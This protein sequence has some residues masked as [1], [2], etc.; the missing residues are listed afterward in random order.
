MAVPSLFVTAAVLAATPS[1]HA[2]TAN[3][4]A[5]NAYHRADQAVIAAAKKVV[6]CERAHGATA[7]ACAPRRRGLQAAGV[8]L[9]R[10]QRTVAR[11][12]RTST[13]SA[14][15]KAPTLS[16]T[17][18]TLKWTKVADVKSYILITKAAG[19]TDRYTVVSGTTTTPAA[20]PG[21]TVSY[22][23]RTAVVGSA[24][25][26]TL[27]ISYPK[28]PE[29]TTTTTTGPAPATPPAPPAGGSTDTGTTAPS[30]G[31]TTGTTTTP[32]PSA[33]PAT[34]T[35]GSAPRAFQVGLVSN[36]AYAM[37][38]PVLQSLGAKTARLEFDIK[39]PASD[40]ASFMDTYAKAGIRPLLLAGF[41]GRVPTADEA[42][43]V[44]SWAKA[45]GPGGTFW[46]GKSY[47]ANTAVTAIEFGNESSQA[48]QYS[49]IS[50]NG[51]W[52]TTSTYASIA[53]GY[54]TA[55]KTAAQA[56]SAA[57]AN[58]GLLA[59]ADV[60][61]NWSSWMDNIYKAVPNFASYVSGWTMHPYG[62]SSR[63]QP[64][65]D[66]TLSILAAHGAP[67][68]LPIY[69][70]EY[71]IA[72]D[73][74]RCLDDNYGWDKC[75]TYDAAASALSSTV[76]AM[77]ARYGSRLAAMYL[78][79]ANDQRASGT[80]SGREYYF[81]SL[82]QSNGAKGAYTATVKSLLAG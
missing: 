1:A 8:K 5:A 27:S 13:F 33:P 32:A 59:I 66:Q 2:A 22:G 71:G 3:A 4:A 80:T 78:Y 68:N 64:N 19:R 29:G 48:Y 44:A 60:P 26:K 9:S 41:A 31:T 57:N 40:L 21:V 20:Q 37:E 46:Q 65:M 10:L 25:S 11:A 12:S 15:L 50:S 74:G 54:A 67:A 69:I 51:S 75:M 36:S 35:T 82:T 77:R 53:Q 49:S 30:T 28:T 34:G 70:T 24:W 72:T 17:G 39:T 56:V 76:G 61:G 18:V 42:R 58:V 6:A 63:W 14:R 52:A 38:L 23:V 7:A 43:N 79:Q 81:G 16:A 55:F 47:P 45:Y 73:G 62:P